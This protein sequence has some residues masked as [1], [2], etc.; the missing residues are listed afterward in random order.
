MARP[1]LRL[2]AVVTCD[3]C[4][5]E[6]DVLVYPR[7]VTLNMVGSRIDRDIRPP[8]G[9]TEKTHQIL[10]PKCSGGGA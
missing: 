6:G 1:T 3:R 2:R 10:C 7:D 5:V 4:D 8:E 9:W